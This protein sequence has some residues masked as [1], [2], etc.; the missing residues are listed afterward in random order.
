MIIGEGIYKK[1]NDDAD[2]RIKDTVKGEIDRADIAFMGNGNAQKHHAHKKGAFFLPYQN[3]EFDDRDEHKGQKR[4][5]QDFEGNVKNISFKDQKEHS[6]DTANDGC[7][8]PVGSLVKTVFS[9]FLDAEDCGNG[10]VEWD[11]GS[12][13]GIDQKAQK[14]SDHSFI[15][16]S[17]YFYGKM[18]HTLS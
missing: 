12:A 15:N 11:A 5:S 16:T 9:G 7:D 18:V 4:V 14:H 1:G 2:G 10:C 17:A 6:P 8:L 3:G 13:H